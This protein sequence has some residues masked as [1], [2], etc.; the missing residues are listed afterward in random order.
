MFVVCSQIFNRRDPSGGTTPRDLPKAQPHHLL[1]D[2]DL[3]YTTSQSP[4]QTASLPKQLQAPVMPLASPRRSD[5]PEPTLTQSK[6]FEFV[7]RGQR[8]G[9]VGWGCAVPNTKETLQNGRVDGHA[10]V[11][12]DLNKRHQFMRLSGDPSFD[13]RAG[14][15]VVT[16]G[17]LRKPEG[18]SARP[19]MSAR[20]KK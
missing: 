8:S 19:M 10:L 13:K 18:L 2:H 20:T 5:S 17:S 1:D 12:S 3:V 16:Q 15:M 9:D 14:R 7:R 6:R 11:G 4:P